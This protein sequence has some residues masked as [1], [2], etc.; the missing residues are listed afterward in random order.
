MS[1]IRLW[2]GE[3][4]AIAP[5]AATR[6]ARVAGTQA[7]RSRTTCSA[8]DV[9]A[10]S[11]SSPGSKLSGKCTFTDDRIRG[12]AHCRRTS[13]SATSRS[14]RLSRRGTSRVIASASAGAPA[15]QLLRHGG[16]NPRL[17]SPTIGCGCPRH[18]LLRIAERCTLGVVAGRASARGLL[19]WGA[20]VAGHDVPGRYGK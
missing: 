4:D 2:H 5:L 12:V 14:R 20:P 9:K 16:D 13:A 19:S 3:V 6:Q 17:A 1:S 11:D 10:R 15:A 8:F 7:S 18:V